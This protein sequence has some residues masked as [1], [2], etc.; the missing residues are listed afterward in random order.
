MG[1]AAPIEATLKVT[2]VY[3]INLDIALFLTC[4]CNG[5]LLAVRVQSDTVSPEQSR[6]ILSVDV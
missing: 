4:L 2:T 5:F 3:L 6:C 1:D